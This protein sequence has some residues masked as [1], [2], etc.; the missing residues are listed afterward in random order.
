MSHDR[1]DVAMTTLVDYLVKLDTSPKEARAFRSNPKKAM[2]SAGLSKKHQAA[3]ESR[4]PQRIRELIL[5][6]NPV[7]AALCIINR[8]FSPV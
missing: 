8:L 6:E 5:V 3:L 2:A 7:E 4:N 1:E